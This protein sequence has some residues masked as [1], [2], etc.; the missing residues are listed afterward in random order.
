MNKTT[1]NNQH[2]L[3]NAKM[4]DFANWEMPISY[5]TGIIKETLFVR[6]QAGVFDV[7]HMGRLEVIGENAKNFIETL[8]PINVDELNNNS[9]KY[10]LLI[11]D[12]GEVLDDAIIYKF[13]ENKFLI[14]I[15][16][17]RSEIDIKWIKS[18]NYKVEINDLTNSTSMLAVQGPES[19]NIIKKLTGNAINDLKRYKFKEISIDHYSAFVT[20]TGY[21]GED[22]VEII[23]NNDNVD[24]LWNKLLKNNIFPCGLGSRDILRLEAGLHLYGHEINPS[25]NP[26]EIRLK[27][28]FKTTTDN[29][30]AK[31]YLRSIMGNEP[32]KI[33]VGLIMKDRG[34][35]R[36][37]CEIELN[38]EKIGYVT[39]G[40]HSPTI[41]KSIAIGII[42]KQFDNVNNTVKIKIREKNL[43]ANI[44]KLPFYRRSKK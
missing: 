6:N 42:N 41:N 16:A 17:S 28:V 36:Q 12:K 23:T 20:R 1:L 22:G 33:M 2:K 7:S 19:L 9:A 38:S 44:I 18:F 30:I 25:S 4:V 26:I 31:D 43:E 5:P 3:L 39:S 13:N 37:D 27:R 8:F 14:I 24:S 15:N 40:T 21:T 29:Y 11:S 35:P 10:T 34:I 32:K